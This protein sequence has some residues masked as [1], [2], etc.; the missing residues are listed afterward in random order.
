MFTVGAR[1]KR[2]ANRH[3]AVFTHTICERIC[4]K[5]REVSVD[6]GASERKLSVSDASDDGFEGERR[7]AIDRRSRSSAVS[8]AASG[9]RLKLK[10][11]LSFRVR[12]KREPGVNTT[13]ARTHHRRETHRVLGGAEGPVRLDAH[14]TLDG[15]SLQIAIARGGWGVGQSP[16]RDAR[17]LATRD[18]FVAGEMTRHCRDAVLRR[19][20]GASRTFLAAK[21]FFA[22]ANWGRTAVAE[23]MACMIFERREVSSGSCADMAGARA[24]AVFS[25]TSLEAPPSLSRKLVSHS[26][27]RIS[28][29]AILFRA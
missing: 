19:A 4:G 18:F 16:R 5:R 12:S 27:T 26:S 11:A 28:V 29:S 13:S 6:G 1:P 14:V 3:A 8:I 25:R 2:P 21:D 9:D 20:R 10:N 24:L 15:D 17:G 23:A 7:R 22:P